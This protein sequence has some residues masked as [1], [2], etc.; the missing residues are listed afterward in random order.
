[1][2]IISC[3]ELKQKKENGEDIIILDVRNTDEFEAGHIEGAINV[4]LH[5]L[6]LKIEQTIPDKDASIMCNCQSGG[7]SALA[8]QT[9][10]KMGYTH[11]YNLKGGY[12][13]YACM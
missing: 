8:T 6:P 13:E 4:P 10:Q 2:K 9:L 3:E 11:V 7:R 1:M 5:L 12:S